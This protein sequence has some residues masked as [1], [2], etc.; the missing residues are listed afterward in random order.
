[1][2]SP[3]RIIV[4]LAATL[5][6]AA[7]SAQQPPAPAPPQQ[8]AE[9]E[10]KGVALL[11]QEA[12]KLRPLTETD[13]GRRFLDAAAALP[14]IQPRMLYPN[15]EKRQWLT[16]A[17]Y[18]ALPESDRAGFEALP[19]DE[20][21][22]YQTKY[23]S[24]LAYV[25]AI[26]LI[27]RVGGMTEFRARTIADYGYGTVG[28][29][30]MMA[31][32]GADATGIDVDPFLVALYSEPGDTGPVAAEGRHGEGGR[33][34]LVNGLW[35]GGEGVGAKVGG[36]YDL[37]LSKNTLKNGYIHPEKEVDKRMLVD[38]SV[39]EEQYVRAVFGALK[40]GG[41]FVI[42]NISPRPSRE[43]EQYKPW[44][45]GRCPFPRDMLESA[46][47]EVLA[48]DQNDDEPARRMFET[49]AYP[50]K[51]DDGGDDLFAWYTIAR[52]R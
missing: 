23:G 9:P 14:T 20:D 4:F 19:S 51:A 36:G 15:R 18:D 21:R 39:P 2:K 8:P 28:H 52:R 26:D 32:M 25:R 5:T 29:L 34:T 50:T 13:L 45:D 42:Y 43:G 35:P 12:G 47:F 16:K 22:Y 31:S 48:F 37:F 38:L 40:P 7:A 10:L 6:A 24:P 30:R 49:L 1:M 11:R 41:L 44:A 17:A 27:A 3:S 33:V 46:G